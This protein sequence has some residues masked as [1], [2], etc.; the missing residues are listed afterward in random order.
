MMIILMSPKT[1][2]TISSKFVFIGTYTMPF[3]YEN[4]GWRD[5]RKEKLTN[6]ETVNKKQVYCVF[7]K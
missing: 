1:Q 2:F 5:Y 7:E 4:F 3:F 6:I